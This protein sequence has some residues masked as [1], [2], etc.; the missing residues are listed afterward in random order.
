MFQINKQFLIL[1]K[2][3]PT[4]YTIEFLNDDFIYEIM[5]FH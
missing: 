5:W 4:K 1:H 2:D 3:N